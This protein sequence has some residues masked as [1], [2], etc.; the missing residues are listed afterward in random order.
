MPDQGL[1]MSAL[2]GGFALPG[3]VAEGDEFDARP[4]RLRR[5]R[6]LPPS[7]RRRSRAETGLRAVGADADRWL[8]I[9]RVFL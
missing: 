3:P 5:A 4:G 9:A 7:P 2:D 1:D 6:R 8:D